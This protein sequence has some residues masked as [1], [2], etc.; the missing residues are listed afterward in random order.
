MNIADYT[1]EKYPVAYY[2]SH[3]V[4]DQVKFVTSKTKGDNLPLTSFKIELQPCLDHNNV[5]KAP[6]ADYYPLEFD[7]LE[8]DCAFVE[9]FE[10][11][12]D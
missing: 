3:E 8:E 6:N 10:E 7:R 12:F 2:K 1:T 5:S 11:K 4:N 9:Q